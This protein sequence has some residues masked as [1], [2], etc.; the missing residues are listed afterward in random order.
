[1][2]GFIRRLELVLLVVATVGFAMPASGRM[3]VDSAGRHVDVPENITRV[4]AAGPPADIFLYVMAPERMLGWVRPPRDEDKPFL[5]P[6]VRELP[7]LGRLTGRGDTMN[8]E[9]LIA[10]KPDIIVDFG[11]MNETYRSLAD[12]VQAQTGIPYV[13]IDGSFPATPGSLRLFADI[14]KVPE[15]GEALARTAE[16]IFTRVDRVIAS[17]P[18]ASRPRVYFARG[19]DGFQTGARGSINTEIIERVGA[20]NVVEGFLKEG[21][22]ARVS[23]EQVINWAPD[24]IVTIDTEA[25]RAVLENPEWKPVPA[26]QN[27]RVLL[28]PSRPFGS[29][30]SPPS[31]SRLIGL[32]ILIS[33][34]YDGEARADLRAEMRSFYKLFYQIDVS[35]AD[36]D[37]LLEGMEK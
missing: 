12:R 11:S 20:V 6:I 7:R 9:R 31:V 32:P 25:R 3:V 35:D 34:F 10:M 1:M 15:R 21:G 17:V 19:S 23:A 18:A 22:M 5:L 24:T 28:P 36:L 14:L 27:R 29:V 37:S 30:D 33:A 8:I 13:L 4:Y 26:V 2:K 16:Q